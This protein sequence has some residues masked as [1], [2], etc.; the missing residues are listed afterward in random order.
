MLVEG[1]SLDHPV[2]DPL[3]PE[4]LAVFDVKVI[5]NVHPHP[6]GDARRQKM[7]RTKSGDDSFGRDD[8]H[9]G[10]AEKSGYER[11]CRL[12]VDLGWSSDLAND[13]LRHD[14]DSVAHGHRFD[15]IVCDIDGGGSEP[16]LELLQLLAGRGGLG[17]RG[18]AAVPES[19]P[20]H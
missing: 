19:A 8:V 2:E 1:T 18:A 6:L 12:V 3:R 15:L 16:L 9:W 13:S 4:V 14:H 5:G 17:P 20:N 7:L 10:G 11:V